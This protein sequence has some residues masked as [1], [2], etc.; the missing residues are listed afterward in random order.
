MGGKITDFSELH[1][2]RNFQRQCKGTGMNKIRQKSQ[3]A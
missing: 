2:I 1:L 3:E